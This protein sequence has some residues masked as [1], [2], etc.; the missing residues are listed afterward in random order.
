VYLSSAL[1]EFVWSPN[2]HYGLSTEVCGDL[3]DLLK[4][5]QT[6]RGASFA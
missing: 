4:S 6:G 3:D 5:P 1:L 2:E